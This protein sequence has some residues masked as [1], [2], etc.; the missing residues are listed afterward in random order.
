MRGDEPIA[1][2]HTVPPPAPLNLGAVFVVREVLVDSHSSEPISVGTRL[3]LRDSVIVPR[4]LDRYLKFQNMANGRTSG[5]TE[6]DPRLL[7]FFTEP[8]RFLQVCDC[9][10]TELQEPAAD[11]LGGLACE[12][13]GDEY[14]IGWWR[15][16]CDGLV[17]D[18][19]RDGLTGV[20]RRVFELAAPQMEERLDLA[21][22]CPQTANAR[23]S[24]PAH[25]AARGGFA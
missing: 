20:H 7:P 22:N 8:K 23:C 18:V 13:M 6:A 21:R 14:L 2:L 16:T 25:Q 11:R 5:L 1:V 24:C 17:E 4:E 19:L 3:L 10:H 12:V 15:C 9:A